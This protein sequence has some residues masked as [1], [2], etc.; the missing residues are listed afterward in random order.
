MPEDFME[1][2]PEA[3][4][5]VNFVR[6]LMHSLQTALTNRT[7]FTTKKTAER[8]GRMGVGP[9]CTQPG[10]VVV[11]LFG[12]VFC[13]VLRR[14]GDERGQQQQQQHY[15]LVGDA[16]VHGIMQGKL[17]Q[18]VDVASAASFDII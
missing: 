1:G 13:V 11:L 3:D 4:R 12:A 18:G 16:Y 17:V 14:V 5:Y 10:D 9:Y 8:V 2:E 7:F 15:R 6:P